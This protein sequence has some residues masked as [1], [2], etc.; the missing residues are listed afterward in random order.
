M[1][2]LR[3]VKYR[4][5]NVTALDGVDLVWERGER[6]AL[7]GANG[8][9][10]STLAMLAKGLAAPSEGTVEIDGIEATAVLPGKVGMVFQNPEDQ[11][12]AATVE[13]EAAFGLENL[14]ICREEMKSKVESVLRSFGLWEYRHHPPHLLS[15]GQ[16]QKLALAST[17]VMQPD[18]LIFDESTSMLD[19]ASRKDFLSS[20]K[21][22]PEQTGVMFITQTAKEAMTFPRLV[23]LFKGRIFFDGDAGDFFSRREL[24]EGA[25]IEPPVKIKLGF[26]L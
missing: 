16:M 18:Y 1:I 5:P 17:L 20:L 14:G 2:R 22:L 3:G 19:P 15:G 11:I 9:G 25:G 21:N 8:S 7:M 23:V 26:G 10:K 12:A 6:I 24:W 4:Y 13:R